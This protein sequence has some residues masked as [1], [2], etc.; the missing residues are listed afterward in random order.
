MK[1]NQY[2]EVFDVTK[3]DCISAIDSSLPDLLGTYILVK[4]ME[5]VSAKNINQQLDEQHISVGEKISITHNGM[6]KKGDSV[7]VISIIQ[8]QNKRNI[9]FSIEAKTQGKTIAKARHDR[10]IISTKLINRIF[11]R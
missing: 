10:V 11:N 6:V 9:S 7:E 8:K 2:S 5:I 4:W 3:S 1:N